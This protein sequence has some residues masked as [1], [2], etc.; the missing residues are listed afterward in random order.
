VAAGV[1][2]QTV[3]NVL[4]S[5]GIVRPATRE[6]VRAV[7]ETLGYRPHASARRLRTRRSA[8]LAVR[9]DPM[10]N[11]ISGSVLDSFL[12]ALTQQAERLGLRVV[13]YTATDPDDETR[14][15]RRLVG[16]SDVDAFV[17]TS[18]V[19]GDP[20]TAWLLEAG[21][22]FVTFGRPW[23]SEHDD[24]YRWVDVDG[25]W[26][27]RLATEHLLGGGTAR[28]GFVGWPE[29][30][31]SGDERR[32]GWREA[33]VAAGTTG[34]DLEALGVACADDLAAGAAA[35]RALLRRVPDID[36]VVAASDTLAVA[37]HAV[38]AGRIPVV[39]FDN[40]S[41]AASFGLSSVD[42]RLSTVAS[43]VLRLAGP[44]GTPAGTHVLV[45][46]RL[47]VRAVGEGA[48]LRA[49]IS[50]RPAETIRP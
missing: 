29:G 9:I 31:G 33:M 47:V 41:V 1:S 7:I 45:K 20:R 25:R 50:P 28:V 4:N 11:G 46:P 17:L 21:Q 40:T 2:R 5:P 6:R 16:G 39:G 44:A 15:I 48:V 18:T 12:H 8:T 37:A 26:G 24:R 27:V 42:Q 36:G 34:D 10:V 43:H 32:A 13:L 22:P 30:S 38:V 19:R 35:V 49:A 14:V 3:S 23:G